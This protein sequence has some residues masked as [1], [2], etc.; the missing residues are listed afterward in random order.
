MSSAEADIRSR[1]DSFASEL[2]TLIRRSAL[3]AVNAALGG[4]HPRAATPVVV[5]PPR[6]RAPAPRKPVAQRKP[7]AARAASPAAPAKAAAPK[8]AAK[9]RGRGTKRPPREIKALV[10]KLASYISAHPGATMEAMRDALGV[11]ST[12]LA[13]PAKKLIAAGKLRVEGKK[14]LTR[15]F[16]A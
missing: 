6:P 8:I 5:A 16:A 4:S 13:V 14:Q 12:D 9:E 3:E 10:D 1:I 7:V 11:P 15:Y 2:E